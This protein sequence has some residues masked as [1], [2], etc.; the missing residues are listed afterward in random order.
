MPEL[1]V[2]SAHLLDLD[3][4]T[5]YQ[6]AKLR[7]DV[8]TLEQGATDADLDG[9]ELEESTELLWVEEDGEAIAHLR[10]LRE[11]DGTV[12]IGRMAVR[13]DRRR[14]G[15]GRRL[16][17][18]GIARAREIAGDGGVHIDAQA[19]LEDWY[20]SMGFRTVSEVFMEA[21]IEHV[22]MVLDAPRISPRTERSAH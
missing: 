5:V 3:A 12:R 22:A 9:R 11:A 8:F 16:M 13:A 20:T 21:G 1:I 10:I 17:E 15:L 14:G 2:K 19:Y 18:A 7:Q 6:L 4:R